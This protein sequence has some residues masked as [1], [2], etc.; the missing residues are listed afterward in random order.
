MVFPVRE[1]HQCN[2]IASIGFATAVMPSSDIYRGGQTVEPSTI[3]PVRSHIT[4]VGEEKT[5]IPSQASGPTIHKGSPPLIASPVISEQPDSNADLVDFLLFL[6]AIR[7]S[8]FLTKRSQV[9]QRL[10]EL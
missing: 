9:F 5:P 2:T 10:H 4:Q 3:A 8:F 1:S 6:K 7:D